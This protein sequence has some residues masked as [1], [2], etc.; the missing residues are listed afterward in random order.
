[1]NRAKARDFYSDYYE[2]TLDRGLTQMLER[3]LKEDSS[4]REDYAQFCELMGNL[5]TLKDIEVPEPA[6]LHER[7]EQRMN[8]KMVQ[9]S[10]KP[11]FWWLNWGRWAFAGAAAFAALALV[12]NFTSQPSSSKNSVANLVPEISIQGDMPPKLV[13]DEAGLTLLF[14]PSS[15]ARV[16]FQTVD[17]SSGPN[18]FNL[19]AG[20]ELRSPVIND[21]SSAE[22]VEIKFSTSHDSL[23]VAVPG[24]EIVPQRSGTGTVKDLALALAN[25][26]GRPVQIAA[27][28]P[29]QR[30]V[31]EFK[32]GDEVDSVSKTLRQFELSLES[33]SDGILFLN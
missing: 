17:S 27:E 11:A 20:Q 31:W 29:T 25:T 16:V 4:L 6:F 23:L 22:L 26:F 30:I 3:A 18:E 10:A 2:G 21:S 32:A 19:E 15:S 28:K 12:I 7:I 13:R 5:D 14:K 8:E 24:S 1:M 9:K 33:R